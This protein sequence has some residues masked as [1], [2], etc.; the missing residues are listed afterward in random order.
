MVPKKD[1]ESPM[2]GKSDKPGNIKKSKHRKKLARDH[3]E[4]TDELFRA[5][6]TSK[7]K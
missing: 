6:V 1:A 3:K 7:N 4:K 2:D 5:H